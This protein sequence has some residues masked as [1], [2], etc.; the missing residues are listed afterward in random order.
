[1]TPRVGD[2]VHYVARGSADGF[3]PPIC[4]AAWVT[5]VAPD[6]NVGLFVANPTGLFFHPLALA[7]GVAHHDGTAW[8]DAPVTTCGCGTYPGG[9]WH[10]PEES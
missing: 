9:T 5:E 8:T 10:H 3:F 1:M 2:P 7:G 4:R 6:G